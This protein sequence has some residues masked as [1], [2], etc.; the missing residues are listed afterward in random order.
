MMSAHRDIV[1]LKNVSGG[2]IHIRGRTDGKLWPKTACMRKIDESKCDVHD[3]ENIDV[4]ES[5]LNDHRF[6]KQCYRNEMFW[7]R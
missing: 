1:V 2:K 4:F 3:P 7:R 6:C 5:I